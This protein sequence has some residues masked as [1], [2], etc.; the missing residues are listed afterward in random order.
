MS[1][2]PF[3]RALPE[4][5]QK[6][7]V[8]YAKFKSY[9]DGASIFSR[10]DPG[11][12]LF[13]VCD[14]TVKIAMQ[15]TEGKD[16][17][18]SLIGKGE[19]FGEIALLDGLPRTAN[20]IAFTDCELMIVDRRDLFVM[21]ETYPPLMLRFIKVLCARLRK[22]TAQVETIVFVDAMGRLAK[23][24]ILLSSSSDT[25][26]HIYTSQSEIAQI[27]GVSREIANK[28]LRKWERE[29]WIKLARKEIKIL[30]PGELAR[31]VA[32]LEPN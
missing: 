2:H 27:A 31:L 13:I 6:R 4:Q 26:G 22:T 32:L 5:I 19:I 8:S 1:G 21:L 18:F 29:S 28:Q 15:S 23:T 11:D 3:F 25:P 16:I 10:G 7:L 24:L 14:G 12:S 20:A 9:E 17:V 30:Q